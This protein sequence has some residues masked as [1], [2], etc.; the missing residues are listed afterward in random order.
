M[1]KSVIK[2]KLRRGEPALVVTL[3]LQ[4]ASLYEMTSLM[5]FDGIWVDM[6]HHALGLESVQHFMR[7]A[8][9]GRTDILARPAKGEFMRM[10]RM[11]EVGAQ[12]ILYPRCDN[13]EEAAEVVRWAK[14][15]PEGCRGIDSGNADNPYC[16]VPL[17]D[18]LPEANRETFIA[19]QIEDAAALEH[20]EA[21]AA[22]DGVDLLFLGPGD[23]TALSGIPGQMNH[24]IIRDATRRVAAAAKAAGKTWGRPVGSAEQ[25][26]EMLDLGAG[27]LACGADL[28]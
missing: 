26:R 9:V 8:R 12:G 4:D 17:A 18:Y 16:A 23:F 14:F 3:H 20:A 15:P 13:A 27:F 2:A 25:A 5:G 28:L 7:A 19:I 1:R 10:G 24:E 22:V 6:E 21:I 11:L